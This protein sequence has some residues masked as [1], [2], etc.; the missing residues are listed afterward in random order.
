MTTAA[1]KDAETAM[2]R[3]IEG[4]PK[5]LREAVYQAE[6]QGA[7][8]PDDLAAA[9]YRMLHQGRIE[10]DGQYRLNRVVKGGE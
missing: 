2:L 7:G 6:H 4:Q 5:T 3:V 9:A 10:L 1:L 8:N